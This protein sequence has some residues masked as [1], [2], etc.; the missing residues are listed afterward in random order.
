M[1]TPC[2]IVGIRKDIRAQINKQSEDRG[3]VSLNER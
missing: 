1:K 2:Y 3:N